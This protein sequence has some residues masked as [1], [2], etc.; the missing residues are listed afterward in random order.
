MHEV[1]KK[2]NILNLLL[3]QQISFGIIYQKSI[4]NSFS[5][6]ERKKKNPYRESK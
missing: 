2:I 5:K 6:K 1:F 4:K 3:S